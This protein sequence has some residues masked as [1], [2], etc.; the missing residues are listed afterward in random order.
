MQQVAVRIADDRNAAVWCVEQVGGDVDAFEYTVD[1]A[2]G[3]ALIVVRNLD[4]ARTLERLLEVGLAV[5]VRDL[6]RR[7]TARS[8]PRMPALDPDL[9]RGR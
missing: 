2:T 6:P 5:P 3:A 9:N 8:M 7:I 1:Y 4:G